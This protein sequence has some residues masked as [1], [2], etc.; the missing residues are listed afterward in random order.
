MLDQL[1]DFINFIISSIQYIPLPPR[2][3]LMIIVVGITVACWIL[4]AYI[5]KDKEKQKEVVEIANYLRYN[6]KFYICIL[7]AFILSIII[8]LEKKQN[9]NYNLNES[10]S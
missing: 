6:K 4:W 1:V 5:S 8:T 9:T 2:F 3:K 10:Q 7:S